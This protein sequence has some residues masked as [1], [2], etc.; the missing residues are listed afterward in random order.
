MLLQWL[1]PHDMS[2]HLQLEELSL[3]LTRLRQHQARLASVRNF[4]IGQ[5]LQHQLTVPTCQVSTGGLSQS[6]GQPGDK[7][8]TCQS[9]F[10]HARALVCICCLALPLIPACLLLMLLPDT[11]QWRWGPC[12]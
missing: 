12:P 2:A 5:L 6:C 9:V 11:V 4:A 10:P 7:G 8:V 3:L 1:I